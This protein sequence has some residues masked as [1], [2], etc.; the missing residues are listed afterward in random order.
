MLEQ[1]VIGSFVICGTVFIQAACISS[2]TALLQGLSSWI[3]AERHFI[4]NTWILSLIVLWLVIGLV[5]TS[6]LWSAVYMY[7]DVFD[8]LEEAWY[9]SIVTFA[10][11][12]YGDIVLDTNWRILSSMTALNGLILV[13]LNTAYL[14]QTFA[15]IRSRQP[16][17]EHHG[18]D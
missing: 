11:L 6:W 14:A 13:G 15:N 8:T 5:I 3:Y 17:P 12:G 7:L 1:I 4:K 18:K 10:T 2:L 16:H 9:F